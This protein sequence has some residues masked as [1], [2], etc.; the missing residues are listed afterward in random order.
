MPGSSAPRPCKPGNLRTGRPPESL[1]SEAIALERA[2]ARTET[3]DIIPPSTLY[4][5][6]R[7]TI[8]CWDDKMR[9]K[10]REMKELL[11]YFSLSLREVAPHVTG[12]TRHTILG[13]QVPLSNAYAEIFSYPG[14]SY[15]KWYNAAYRL[16]NPTRDEYEANRKRAYAGLMRLVASGHVQKLKD[17]N[18][19]ITLWPLKSMWGQTPEAPPEQLVQLAANQMI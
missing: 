10:F 1:M 8:D 13:K 14:V 12:R 2:I 11:D 7:T 3:H 15:E 19:I 9:K 17:E 18:G 5:D 4:V 16:E 6:G